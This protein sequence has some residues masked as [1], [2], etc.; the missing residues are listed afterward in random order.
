MNPTMK[1]GLLMMVDMVTTNAGSGNKSLTSDVSRIRSAITE[2]IMKELS[3]VN[4][5]LA[6]NMIMNATSVTTGLL[7][8]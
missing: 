3:C 4:L 5:A 1:S 2:K 8:L 7:D 6:Q